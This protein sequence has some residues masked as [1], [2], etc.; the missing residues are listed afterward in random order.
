MV[1]D[2][3]SIYKDNICCLDYSVAKEGR[4]AAYSFDDEAVLQTQKFTSV[5]WIK[6]N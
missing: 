6:P 3:P 4:L 5:A 2:K 1:E